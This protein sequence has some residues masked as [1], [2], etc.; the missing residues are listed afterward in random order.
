MRFLFHR[1][2]FP[3]YHLSFC[4]SGANCIGNVN[5]LL[6]NDACYLSDQTAVFSQFEILERPVVGLPRL[7]ALERLKFNGRD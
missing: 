3:F 5:S 6:T 7:A 2:P 4:Q 1:H